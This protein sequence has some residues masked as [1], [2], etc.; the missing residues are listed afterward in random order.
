MEH[1]I[2]GVAYVEPAEAARRLGLSLRTLANQRHEDRSRM[3]Y[4][5]LAGR[6]LYPVTEVERYAR[7]LGR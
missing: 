7:E 5:K 1:T 2:D 4:I 3:R 6:V